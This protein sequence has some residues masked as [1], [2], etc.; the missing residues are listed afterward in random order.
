M[1]PIVVHCIIWA[2][3]QETGGAHCAVCVRFI[4]FISYLHEILL[5]PNAWS[6][7]NETTLRTN[8]LSPKWPK[9]DRMPYDVRLIYI[10]FNNHFEAGIK[11]MFLYYTV[12]EFF[13]TRSRLINNYLG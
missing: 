3:L 4:M 7:G 5:A 8:A 13:N 2:K 6:M 9:F 1:L 12:I 10:V 11:L